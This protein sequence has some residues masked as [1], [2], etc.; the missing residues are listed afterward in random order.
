MHA[1]DYVALPKLPVLSPAY[2]PC[3]LVMQV[4]TWVEGTPVSDA[5]TIPVETLSEEGVF[6]GKICHALDM[7]PGPQ[8]A[9]SYNHAWDS[10]NTTGL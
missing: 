3:I 2:S 1:G 9:S 8:Q 7:L 6:Q 5:Y 4:L 10:R